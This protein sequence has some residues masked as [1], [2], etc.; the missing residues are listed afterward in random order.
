MADP[1]VTRRSEVPWLIGG[2]TVL[3]IGWYVINRH[4]LEVYPTDATEGGTIHVITWGTDPNPARVEQCSIFNRANRDRGLKVQV[5]PNGADAQAIVTRSAAGNAPDCI[6]IYNPE[7]LSKYI[8][9]GIARPLNEHLK[10]AQLDPA[11]ETWPA[12]IEN[13]SR[14]NPDYKPGIDDPIDARIWYAIPNNVDYAFIYFNRTLYQRVVAERQAAGTPVPPEPWLGWTW[15]DYAAIAKM[16][17]RRGPDGR[18][19]SFGGAAPDS[20]T[21]AMS[22]GAGMRGEDRAAFEAL[23]PEQRSARG[24]QGLDWDSAIAPFVKRPDGTLQPWP[25][26]AAITDALQFV[27]DIQHAWRAVPTQS[28]MQ[29]MATGGG[30]YGGA[31][32]QGQFLAGNAGMMTMGRWYLGQIRANASFDWRMLRMP[33][34]VPYDE[35]ARWQR[36]GKGPG[37]RDGEWGDVAHPNRGYIAQMNTRCSFLTSSSP[38]PAKA[39]RFLEMLIRNQDY[40]RVILLED[41][42]CASMPMALDY[43]SKPD[44]LVPDEIINRAPEH[45]IAAVSQQAPRP[46]WPFSNYARYYTIG[47]SNLAAWMIPRDTLETALKSGKP[48]IERPELAIYAPG[49]SM[50]SVSGIG[51]DFAGRLNEAL[52]DAGKEGY[53]LDQPAR[54]QWPSLGT[55]AVFAGLIAVFVTMALGAMRAQRAEKAHA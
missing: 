4:V 47:W 34:W 19:L 31:G 33:R 54:R 39:F 30:G 45:E 36:E 9:K 1:S 21:L 17:N 2:I 23:T 28:D 49:E 18:F 35:W 15:W 26:H 5:V 6:D 14:P 32:V 48:K 20:T 13:I 40:T 11:K 24:L 3:L 42:A 41:G 8:A 27:H 52:D 7:D 16:L 50:T 55:L 37:Q 29:Q 12:L 43:F 44:P 46:R 53:V 10:N 22:I 51:E 38:D 25:N